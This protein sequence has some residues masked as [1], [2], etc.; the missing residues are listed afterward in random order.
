MGG[1]ILRIFKL[2]LR[3]SPKLILD[4]FHK[5]FW[6]ATI[7]AEKGFEFYLGY[8]N[9]QFFFLDIPTFILYSASANLIAKKRGCKECAIVS[10]DSS[11]I[12]LIFTL[13][14]ELIII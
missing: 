11:S 3:I 9:I 1:P 14:A 13:L 12:K 10:I 2:I 8:N 4:N 7:F 6:I 5:S